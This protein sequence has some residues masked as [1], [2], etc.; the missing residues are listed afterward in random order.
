MLHGTALA[1]LVAYDYYKEVCEG[2]LDPAW[3]KDDLADYW[4]FCDILTTQMCHYN[5]IHCSYP[6]DGHIRPSTSQNGSKR[7]ASESA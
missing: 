2:G 1:T 4:T 5:P 6:G 7:K 3:K